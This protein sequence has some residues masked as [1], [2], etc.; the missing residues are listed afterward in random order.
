MGIVSNRIWD[1]GDCALIFIDYQ[2]SIFDIIYEQDHRLIELNVRT[3]AEAAVAFDIPVILTTVGVKIGANS[4]TI[5][6]L[7]SKLPDIVEIDR[8]SM[9]AWEDDNFVEAVKAT[10][11]K[12][13]VICGI[14]TSTCLTFSALGAM[15]DGYDVM[16]IEDA[17]GDQ[18]KRKHELGV[19]RLIQ[20]GAIPNSTVSVIAEWFRDWKSPFAEAAGNLFVSYFD[21]IIPLKSNPETYPYKGL[22]GN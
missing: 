16:F 1:G 7:R 4:P 8:S 20:A 15:D 9:S 3:L 11:R 14:T 19:E 10:G 6:S 18:Y 2:K 21:E 12:K 17:V 13:L 22:G 5:E